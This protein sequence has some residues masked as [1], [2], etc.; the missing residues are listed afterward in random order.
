MN[1]FKI[2]RNILCVIS[3]IICFIFLFMINGF[4]N[5]SFNL[6]NL[7]IGDQI[8]F[9]LEFLLYSITIIIS[10]FIISNKYLK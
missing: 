4:I 7:N 6:F 9:L 1:S 2:I 3:S 10:I 8:N 5:K